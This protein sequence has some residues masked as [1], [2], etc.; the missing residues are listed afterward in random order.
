MPGMKKK[1]VAI[2]TSNLLI[3]PLTYGE[4]KPLPVPAQNNAVTIKTRPAVIQYAAISQLTTYEMN[5]FKT[6]TL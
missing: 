5:Y 3:Q 4:E 6:K 2:V 1:L